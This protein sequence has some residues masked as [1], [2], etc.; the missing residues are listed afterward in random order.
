MR[1]VADLDEV[2]RAERASAWEAIIARGALPMSC[3]FLIPDNCRARLV[4]MPLGGVALA[5]ASYSAL[6]AERGPRLIRR[7]DPELYEIAVVVAGDQGIEQARQRA[8][9]RRGEMVLHDSSLPLTARTAVTAGMS[10]ALI[11]QF[12]KQLVRLPESRMRELL[13]VPLP[14]SSGVGKLLAT[15]LRGLVEEYTELSSRDLVRAGQNVLDLTVAVLGHFT[16]RDPRLTPESRRHVLYLECAAFVERHL[17][18]PDLSPGL[19][20]R[21]HGISPRYLQLVFQEQDATPSSFIRERRLAHCR[22]DLAD[23][24][25]HAVPVHAIGARWGFPRASEFNR[26]FRR[27]EGVSPGAYRLLVRGGGAAPE[28]PARSVPRGGTAAAATRCATTAVAAPG[29]VTLPNPRF[30]TTGGAAPVGRGDGS[31]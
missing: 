16:D 27:R 2:P 22:R 13:A 24:R 14:A 20:A 18:D 23:P 9:V 17:A 1:R 7:D 15:L 21:A 8:L 26:A 29:R 10:G 19:V 4:S 31:G 12:P 3:R 25:L 28:R 6:V 5:E 30:P 11:L